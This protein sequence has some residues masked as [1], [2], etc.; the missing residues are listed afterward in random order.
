MGKKRKIKKSIQ[1]FQKRIEEHEKKIEEYNGPKKYLIDYWKG[2]IERF[3]KQKTEKEEE[4]K[5]K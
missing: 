5:K 2:E 3:K 1:S 4:L